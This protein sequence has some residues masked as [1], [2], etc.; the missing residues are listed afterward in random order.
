MRGRG[1]VCVS[2][3]NERS[4]L[5]GFPVCAGAGV[6]GGIVRTRAPLLTLI[7]QAFRSEFSQ[8]DANQNRCCLIVIR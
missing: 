6:R 1:L 2:N 8:W 5:S 3:G 7:V 4:M